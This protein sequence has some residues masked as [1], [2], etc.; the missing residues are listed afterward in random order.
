MITLG[1]DAACAHAGGPGRAAAH[2]FSGATMISCFLERIR[3][4]V[5]SFC[6]SSVR[7]AERALLARLWEQA[8]THT[9]FL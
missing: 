9:L 4:K 5:R 7:T 6:G 1:R 8:G 3:R 2:T